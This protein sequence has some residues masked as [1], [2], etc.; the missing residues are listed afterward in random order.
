[1]SPESTD[2]Y[3][4]LSG[5]H[6]EKNEFG[7]L[8]EYASLLFDARALKAL[9]QVVSPDYFSHDK[10]IEDHLQLCEG[11]SNT[12]NRWFLD[13][14]VCSELLM[15]VE[16]NPDHGYSHFRRVEKFIKEIFAKD[17]S[18][19]NRED[20]LYFVPALY[21]AIR[22]HDL[23]EVYSNQKEGHDSAAALLA[24]GVMRE[25]K[26]VVQGFI[27]GYAGKGHFPDKDYEKLTWATVYMCRHHSKPEDM[28]SQKIH[29][30][31]AE[32]LADAEKMA[33]K[34]GKNLDHFFPPYLIMSKTIEEIRNGALD[35]RGLK[36]WKLQ[37]VEA[38]Q[39]MTRILAAGDKLDGYIPEGLSA[40]RTVLTRPERD[41]YVEAEDYKDLREEFDTRVL[42]GK[43]HE[44]NCDLNRLL[45][46]L[47]RTGSFEGISPWI[48]VRYSRALLH[49]GE[50]LYKA[51]RGF[52]EGDFQ[53]YLQA[54]EDL[55]EDMI[56]TVLVKIGVSKGAIA[57][58]FK[59]SDAPR[60]KMVVQ[61]LKD[62][63]INPQI[64]DTLLY[65]LRG[66]SLRVADSLA[67][68]YKKLQGNLNGKTKEKIL[69]LVEMAIDIQ[70]K[71]VVKYPG[72]LEKLKPP[73]N[74][75]Y[76]I[77]VEQWRV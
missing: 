19:R 76:S 1:M 25:A 60:H 32:L 39:L 40:A 33:A 16:T 5:L 75:Y 54:Y 21:L 73:Y 42:D 50:F 29:L 20:L 22:F 45:F 41:Y 48:N 7:K 57:D 10:Q 31:P 35:M 61:L 13:Q 34:T 46:E 9:I 72:P 4:N 58:V 38:L 68:K 64:I 53:S 2:S 70:R 66:E 3:L 71:Q 56:R 65:G 62:N 43:A 49:K 77:N 47:T 36:E 69:K 67:Q 52:L 6:G 27:G 63:H 23:V 15:K 55:E 51:I 12:I 44:S 11:L 26:D 24:L 17:K 18:L 74:G 30:D 14:P 59:F 37:D 8:H 28:P